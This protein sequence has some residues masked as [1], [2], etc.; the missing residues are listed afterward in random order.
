M[1]VHRQRFVG[2]Q[3]QLRNECY[4]KTPDL[5]I[6][7][8]YQNKRSEVQSEVLLEEKNLILNMTNPFEDVSNSESI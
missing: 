1:A 6:Y 3:L 2:V 8:K 5:L 4:E 7:P